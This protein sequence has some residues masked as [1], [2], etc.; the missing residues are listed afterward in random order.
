MML[1]TTS[2][3]TEDQEDP[4]TAPKLKVRLVEKTQDNV[5]PLSTWG[6]LGLSP[7]GAFFQYLQ[8]MFDESKRITI[9]LKY[10]AWDK[11][12]MSSDLAFR[13]QIYMNMLWR[14]HFDQEDILGSWYNEKGL[15]YWYLPGGVKLEGSE[16]EYK[17]EKICLDTYTNDYIG[18]IEGEIWCNRA[19]AAICDLSKNP[20]CMEKEADVTK[21][22]K[23]I[24]TIG[25][26]TL[27]LTGEDYIYFTNDGAM[28]RFGDPCTARDEGTCGK[29]TRIVVGKLFFEKW[30]P[31]LS[32]E[33][34]NGFFFVSLVKKFKAPDEKSETW[35]IV[36]IIAAIIFVFG[37][38]YL[39]VKRKSKNDEAHYIL[40]DEDLKEE[41]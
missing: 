30:V 9:T 6:I 12:L 34:P 18:V 37:V 16:F 39:I 22:P 19:R 41:N 38:I 5:W 35:L 14:E 40:H 15:S 1:E 24:F 8:T 31:I 23:V 28:C 3:P 11:R 25:D 27:E 36:G 4:E 13:S 26:L 33:R 2:K 7:T 20:K 32:W 17:D 21:A 10:H 29:E